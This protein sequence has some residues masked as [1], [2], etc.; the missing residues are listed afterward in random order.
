LDRALVAQGQFSFE[1]GR[2]AAQNLLSKKERPTAIFAANDDMAAGVLYEAHQR[3]ICVPKELS[4]A[5]FDDSPLAQRVWPSLTTV[6]Q[7]IREMAEVAVRELINSARHD[8]SNA[9]QRRVMQVDYELV[10]RQSTS[11]P[12]G[13]SVN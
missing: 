12:G 5:G 1:S 7:P 11:A 8:S 2:R 10:V 6:K 13:T 3:G 4:V 9:R